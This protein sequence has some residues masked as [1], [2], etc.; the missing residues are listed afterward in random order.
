MND[1]NY[2]TWANILSYLVI[3][4]VFWLNLFGLQRTYGSFV[5]MF[6]AFTSAMILLVFFHLVQRF[7]GTHN[8]FSTMIW[9]E[10]VFMLFAVLATIRCVDPGWRFSIG[11]LHSR[12]LGYLMMIGC[13][14]LMLLPYLRQD[15]EHRNPYT[16]FGMRKVKPN[17]HSGFFGGGVQF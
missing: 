1:R 12:M 4:I 2:F 5:A 16:L 11:I 6:I 15:R 9:W 10:R 7:K 8:Q 17:G 14:F 3:V 13:Y